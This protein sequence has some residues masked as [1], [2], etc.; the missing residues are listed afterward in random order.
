M[1]AVTWQ[2]TPDSTVE[3]KFFDGTD[4]YA[5]KTYI[6]AD[7]GYNQWYSANRWDLNNEDIQQLVDRYSDYTI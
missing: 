7:D 5:L 4:N 1:S 2:T 3:T 6:Y